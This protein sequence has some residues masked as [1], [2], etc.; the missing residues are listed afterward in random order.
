[1]TARA[2]RN[3][4]IGNLF[5]QTQQATGDYTRDALTTETANRSF[6]QKRFYRQW[7]FGFNL[8]W[9]LDFWGRYRRAVESAEDTLDASVENYDAVLVTLLGDVATAYV[10]IR[11]LEAQIKLTQANVD[12]QRKTLEIAV[13]RFKGGTITEL[14]V[15]Q[16]QSNLSQTES[17][18]PQLKI[19]LRQAN[20]QLSILLGIPPEDLLP[21]PGR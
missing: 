2:Q 3:V 12:L 1:L 18:V 5:P 15:D 6:V 8:S 21:P 16:A 11:T 9:E 13:A 20:N 17:Q 19:Q 4:A 14:D 10:Q 7:D